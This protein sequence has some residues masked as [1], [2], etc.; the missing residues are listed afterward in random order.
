VLGGTQTL[1][2]LGYSDASLGTGPKGRSILSQVVR[3]QSN[4]G[5]IHAKT[6]ASSMVYLNVFEAELDGCSIVVKDVSRIQ[7]IFDEFAQEIKQTT[8][9][10]DNLAVVDFMHGRGNPKGVRH[11]QLRMWYLREKILSGSI[12]IDHLAGSL[13]VADRLT[14]VSDN[15]GHN[16]FANDIQGLNLLKLQNKSILS[17]GNEIQEYWD[18][19]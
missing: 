7:N 13:I 5:A 15:I 11:M 6:R 17:N 14:K 8:I 3:L 4:A 19:I 9:F 18:V 12:D 2:I 10:G 1:E 16:V